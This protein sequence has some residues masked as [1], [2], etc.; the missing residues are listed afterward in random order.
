MG[1]VLPH[2]VHFYASQLLASFPEMLLFL[3]P[4]FHKLAFLRPSTSQKVNRLCTLSTSDYQQLSSKTKTPSLLQLPGSWSLTLL[5][6]MMW[7]G[8]KGHSRVLTITGPVISK[9]QPWQDSPNF[10]Q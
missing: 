10:P 2:F 8:K 4:L 7:L 6:V 5:S 1:S 9:E 3:T